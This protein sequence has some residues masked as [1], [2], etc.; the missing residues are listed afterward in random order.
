MTTTTVV[1]VGDKVFVKDL[2]QA[3]IRGD[4]QSIAEGKVTVQTEDGVKTA[5]IAD[6]VSSPAEVNADDMIMLQS[7]HES[8]LV[9]CLRVRYMTQDQMYTYVGNGVL[10]AV[11]PFQP[12]KMNRPQEVANFRGKD[13]T[14]VAPH[15]E[16]FLLTRK[17]LIFQIFQYTYCL[18]RPIKL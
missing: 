6:V 17:K 12:L 11:N 15:G 10:M 4:V 2:E 9:E 16:S 14:E 1:N 7:E 5:P 18:V 13:P 3:W 8:A